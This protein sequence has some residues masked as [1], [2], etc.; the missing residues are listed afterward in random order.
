MIAKNT[1]VSSVEIR[2]AALDTDGLFSTINLLSAHCS[3]D[4]QIL[5]AFPRGLSDFRSF[6]LEVSHQSFLYMKVRSALIPI[7]NASNSA[8]GL[9]RI[10]WIED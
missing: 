2:I 7:L 4:S 6:N 9:Q 8:E 3:V 5:T 1:D 10:T